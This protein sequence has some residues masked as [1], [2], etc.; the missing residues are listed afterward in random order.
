MIRS[1][2]G[3]RVAQLEAITAAAEGRVSLLG[4]TMREGEGVPG[5]RT[6]QRA[7]RGWLFRNASVSLDHM[8]NLLES[9]RESADEA[10]F[11][12]RRAAT[13]HAM[14]QSRRFYFAANLVT[15]SVDRVVRQHYRT[16]AARRM[17]ATAIAVTLYRVDH[18][19]RLPPT[20]ADLVPEYLPA[21]PRDPVAGGDRPLGYI[22]DPAGPRIY[23]VGDNGVDDG[24]RPPNRATSRDERY[25]LSDDVV[26]LDR[27][28]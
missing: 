6:L 23:S 3:E 9:A 15:P 8:N 7:L 16:L 11:D 13:P 20:L 4:M 10:T 5:D 1:L 19:G 26:D 28:P 25:K 14:E 17:G 2:R 27:Q 21:V 12:K 24:G 18:E 22:A